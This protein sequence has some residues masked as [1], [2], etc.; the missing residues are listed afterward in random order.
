MSSPL[1][2]RSLPLYPVSCTSRVHRTTSA[3]LQLFAQAF[4]RK[5]CLTLQ[6]R[7]RRPSLTNLLPN[8]TVTLPP[9]RGSCTS[10]VPSSIFQS[11]LRTHHRIFSSPFLFAV[12]LFVLQTLHKIPPSRVLR[13]RYSCHIR[14][15]CRR[16]CHSQR[17]P[18][19]FDHSQG[20]AYP[21]SNVC[22][23]AA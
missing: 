9:I 1:L 23:L 8:R 19:C 2:S 21:T 12:L 4:D 10:T 7:R 18:E 22:I 14:S 15:W 5:S 17:E 6:T 20:S 16:C 3:Y 11:T 13:Y